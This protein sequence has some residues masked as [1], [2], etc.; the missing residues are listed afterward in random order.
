MNFRLVPASTHAHLLAEPLQWSIDQWGIGK[1]EFSIEDWKTFYTAVQKSDYTAWNSDCKDKEL[2]YLAI[3]D[4]EKVLAAIGL[5]DFDDLE[6]FRHLGPWICA[7]I[8]R[9][10]LRGQGLGSEI[11]YAMEERAC[12]F[13]I[14]PLYLWTEEHESF[15]RNRGYQVVDT[16]DKGARHIVVMRK[17][18]ETN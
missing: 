18:F 2:L 11:L 3:T 8:V 10:E 13:G 6:E 9:P 1:E 7:F 17:A 16:L 14:S 12:E 15:Y 5:A 4:D